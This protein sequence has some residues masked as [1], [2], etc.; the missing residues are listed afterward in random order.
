M[1]EKKIV[2]TV[3]TVLL[4][5]LATVHKKKKKGQKKWQ[6]GSLKLYC[7]WTVENVVWT[8]PKHY[9]GIGALYIRKKSTN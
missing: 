2:T 6:S 8:I 5:T 7:R 1:E 9:R 4:G 3:A